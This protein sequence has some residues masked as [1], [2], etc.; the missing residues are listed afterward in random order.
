MR[1]FQLIFFTLLIYLFIFVN[2][3]Q[4]EV[5]KKINVIGNDRI[6]SETIIVFGDIQKDQNYEAEDNIFIENQIK[7]SQI[8]YLDTMRIAQFLYADL[9]SY[10][11]K[12][13]AEY[14]KI[15]NK[16]QHRALEDAIVLQQIF[17]K[18]FEDS[19]YQSLTELYQDLYTA[20]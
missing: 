12:Y 19:K 7:Y 8:R 1:Q 10:S 3:A 6:T 17:N 11:Q 16:I 13:L 15:E 4:T 14:F 9:H 20:Y 18:M 5:V 2:K